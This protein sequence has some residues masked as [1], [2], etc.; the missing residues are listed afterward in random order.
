MRHTNLLF[1]TLL[2]ILYRFY[3]ILLGNYEHSNVIITETS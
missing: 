3:C 1:F 2:K